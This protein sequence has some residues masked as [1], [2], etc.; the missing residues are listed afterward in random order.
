MQLAGAPLLLFVQTDDGTGASGGCSLSSL[1]AQRVGCRRMDG[2][3]WFALL[4]FNIYLF[5]NIESS[6]T[7]SAG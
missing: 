7:M 4:A 1:V 5:N 2:L 3:V 6:F